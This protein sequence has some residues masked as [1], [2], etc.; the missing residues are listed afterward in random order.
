ML[1][2]DDIAEPKEPMSADELYHQFWHQGCPAW[3]ADAV[4]D[5]V[6]NNDLPFLIKQVE[7]HVPGWTKP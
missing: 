4:T 5:A 6:C 2:P 7:R 1:G 3:L